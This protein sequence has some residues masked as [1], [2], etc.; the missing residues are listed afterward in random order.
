MPVGFRRTELLQ[1]ARQFDVAGEINQW[2]AAPGL[3]PPS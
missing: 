2:L 3:Q 1:K